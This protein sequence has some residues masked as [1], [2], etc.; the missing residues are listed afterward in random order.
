[1][2]ES[3]AHKQ[4]REQELQNAK[5]QQQIEQQNLALQKQVFGQISPYASGL[6]GIGNAALKGQAPDF[7]QL[8]TRNAIASAFGGERQNL[9][10]FLGKTGQGFSGI[11]AGPAANLGAQEASAIGQSQAD[12]LSQA[13]GLGLQGGNLFSGQ[14]AVFNPT[15]YGGM[16]TQGFNNYTQATPQSGFW[17]SLGG[18]LLGAGINAGTSWLSPG[19]FFKGAGH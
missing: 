5:L 14:Q 3:S 18:S 9:A 19:G 8:G 17:G 6:L 1:M 7:F 16:A 12:A 11:A 4:A 15:Q 13:L 2:G 10:D